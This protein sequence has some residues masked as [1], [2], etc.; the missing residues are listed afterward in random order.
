M[1]RP[2]RKYILDTH[3]FIDGFRDPAAKETLQQ[4][5][6]LFAP[7]EYLNVV[8]AQELRAGT[9]SLQDRRALERQVLEVFE[10]AGRTIVPSAAA[11]QQSGDVLAEMARKDGLEIARVSKSFANDIILA[12]SCRE[13]GCV[14]VT[15]NTS[16]FT[17]IRRFVPLEFEAPWPWS[18]ATQSHP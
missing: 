1:T 13:A 3:L 10:R 16:D 14:L 8:V 11:W 5:H 6:R 12:I 7:F 15:G 2:Y 17:R 9:R 18:A 4:F